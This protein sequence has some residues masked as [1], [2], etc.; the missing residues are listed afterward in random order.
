MFQ[1]TIK[2]LQHTVSPAAFPA[3]LVAIAF[4][5]GILDATTYADFQ[6]FT[7]NQT[8]NAILLPVGMM[9]AGNVQMLSTGVSLASFLFFG[10]LSG[11]VGHIVG[12]RKRWWM[13]LSSSIQ[14][15]F[16]LIPAALLYTGSVTISPQHAPLL[17]FLLATSAGFQVAMAR[18]LGVNEIPTA[19]LTS[20]FIDF[21][22]DRYLFTGSW[23]NVK[24]T[25]RNRRLF[26]ISALWGGAF[27]GAAMHR[28][29]GSKEVI[30]M[31]GFM[32]VGVMASFWF[33]GEEGDEVLCRRTSMLQ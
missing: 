31:V 27:V 28:Y 7:S 6:T 21:L 2:R 19:M 15:M 23:S 26:Y 18:N 30:L 1:R 20:P 12:H 5:T 4:C 16:V 14:A 11:Q 33:N 29:S 17:L 22:T 8:G 32:K 9:G 25:G 3:Q 24:V 13:L 10:F